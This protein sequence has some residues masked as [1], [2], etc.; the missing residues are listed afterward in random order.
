MKQLIIRI[1]FL[2]IILQLG[3]N[4]V[5]SAQTTPVQPEP[6]SPV[7]KTLA[8]IP[9]TAQQVK[10]GFYGQNVYGLDPSSNTY[11]MDFYM[12][13]KWKGSINPTTKLEF[14]NGV[15]D[16]GATQV[17]TY[18]QPKQLPDGSL[19]Q[20]IRVEGRFTEPFKFV[21]YPLDRQRLGVTIEDSLHTINQLIY[22]PDNEQSGYAKGISIPGW[23]FEK[24]QT[25]QLSHKY[26]T[27]FGEPSNGDNTSTFATIRYELLV[28]RPVSFF[29]W[30]LLLP[31][32]I[33]LLASWGALLLDPL[34]VDSRIALTITTLLTTVFLQQSYSS[35]LPAISYL[36]LLDKIYV[37]AYVLI[38]A[39]ILETI[40]TADIVRSEKTEAIERVKQ[41]DRAF[42][43]GNLVVSFVGVTL[44]LLL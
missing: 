27:N 43:I 22:V 9:K 26:D 17:P 37:L 14:M 35:D 1:I 12:W 19:L 42:L 24:S 6:H 36:V 30:K 31:L 3:V 33:V 38:I 10:V 11:Y 28:S 2:A 20:V 44:L 16:W 5:A 40:L 4:V 41:I 34:R 21:R 18:E 7:Y 25:L 32:I 8:E 15:D 29:A 23:N 13:L 39:A